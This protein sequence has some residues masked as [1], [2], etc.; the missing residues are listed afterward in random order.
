MTV[1]LLFTWQLD[2]DYSD[3]GKSWARKN[4]LATA[5]LHLSPVFL[6]L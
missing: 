3:S 1:Q 2:T 6:N 4:V 5:N